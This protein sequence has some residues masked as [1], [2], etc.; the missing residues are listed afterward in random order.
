[1]S[2]GNSV[3]QCSADPAHANHERGAAQTECW[4]GFLVFLPAET[5]HETGD[6]IG[7]PGWMDLNAPIR[8]EIEVVLPHDSKHQM[9]GAAQVTD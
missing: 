7:R 6:A 2:R 8:S 4:A 9:A 3:C 1:M 5:D